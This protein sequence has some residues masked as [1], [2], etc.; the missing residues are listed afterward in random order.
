MLSIRR[1]RVGDAALLAALG[2]RT[3]MDSYLDQNDPDD[4][5]A[6]VAANFTEPVLAKDLADLRTTYFL[7]SEGDIPSAYARLHRGEAPPCVTG[8]EPIELARFYVV[9]ELHGRGTAAV[10]LNTCLI[11]AKRLGAQTVWLGVWEKN[12]RARA[13]YKKHGFEEVGTHEFVLGKD[14]QQDL[15]LARAVDRP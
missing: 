14:V 1:A 12:A 2:E 13:F 4:M 10:M 5:R 7:G 3:F 8:P 15:V 6:Y 11:E 9:K